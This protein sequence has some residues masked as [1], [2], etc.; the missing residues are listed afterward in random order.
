[1]MD[2]GESFITDAKDVRTILVK[3][4]E[5]KE[6]D[7]ILGYEIRKTRMEILPK[8]ITESK[9]LIDPLPLSQ[10]FAYNYSRMNSASKF[11]QKSM[12]AKFPK[13]GLIARPCDIRAFIELSKY[14][15]VNVDDLFIIGIECPGST[16]PQ[17]ATKQLKA[18]E[19]D[20][21]KITEEKLIDDGLEITIDGKK[22]VLKLPRFD[23][24]QRCS[25]RL[26]RIADLTL[27]LVDGKARITI[28]SERGKNFIEKIGLKGSSDDLKEKRKAHFEQL[29]TNA[30][31]FAEKVFSEYENMTD[32]ERFNKFF[33]DIKKCR[34]CGACINACPLCYCPVCDVQ[35]KRKAK[36]LDDPVLYWMLKMVHMSDACISCGKCGNVCPVKIPNDFYYD[37]VSRR[38]L[39]AFKYETGKAVE[40]LPPRTMKAIKAA[41][42]Q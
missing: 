1:M 29:E 2:I 27:D 23:N 8:L 7:A 5:E 40:D 32:A 24:C 36:E 12:R 35:A 11:Y 39:E 18:K 41:L 30:R 33:S 31:E 37:I 34:L 16:S 42:Q 25:N 6:V 13:A 19:L 9:D 28:K 17:N 26:P 4:L 3:L 14:H 38:I 15:Q 21:E 10:Y 22:E 20:P